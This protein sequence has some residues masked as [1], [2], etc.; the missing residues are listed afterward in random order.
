MVGS[1]VHQPAPL[2]SA[3]RQGGT[4]GASSFLF[5]ATMAA[6]FPANSKPTANVNDQIFH[7]QGK[8]KGGNF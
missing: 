3:A 1:T 4:A 5:C 8:G 2:P 7:D 6:N